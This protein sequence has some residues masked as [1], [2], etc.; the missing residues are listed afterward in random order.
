V[1]RGWTQNELAKRAKMSQVRISVLE[2]P[3]YENFSIKTLKRLAEAFDTALILR[4]APFSEML[5]WLT[6]LQPSTLAVK[7]FSEDS[8]SAGPEE[9]AISV[10]EADSRDKLQDIFA[11]QKDNDRHAKQVS[12]LHS[13][14]GTLMVQ[15]TTATKTPFLYATAQYRQP[16][17]VGL[18]GLP[19]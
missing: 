3:T 15:T 9:M 8:I 12:A 17:M 1:A 13:V 6:T 14:E 5:Q 7:Q 19:R 10:K 2:D 11:L 18:E 4:F 16:P